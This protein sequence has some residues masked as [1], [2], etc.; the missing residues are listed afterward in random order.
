MTF[1][2]A[3]GQFVQADRAQT[4]YRQVAARHKQVDR[5]TH[6]RQQQSDT[7]HGRSYGCA[8]QAAVDRRT[9]TDDDSL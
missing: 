3:D 4:T 5:R 9:L 1:W 7:M 8:A 6:T 2:Q